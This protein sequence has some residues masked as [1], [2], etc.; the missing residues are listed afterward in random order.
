[1]HA[2]LIPGAISGG[3]LSTR[4]FQAVRIS[5]TSDSPFRI[6]EVTVNSQRPIG[7]LQ[8]KPANSTGAPLE[9][10]ILGSVV[11][12][13]YGGAVNNGDALGVDAA[14]LLVS[15]GQGDPSTGSDRYIIA[16]AL[17]DGSSS[18]VHYV[19]VVSPH[20]LAS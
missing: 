5:T 6:D 16:Q 20:L 14:G 12:A 18:E 10:A 4:Q 1:M 19:I 2:N 9:V 8:N 13:K 17:E 15:L 11:K 3:D 7:I